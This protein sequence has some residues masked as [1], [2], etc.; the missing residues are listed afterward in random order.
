MAISPLPTPPSREDPANFATRAD[1]F[2]GALPTFQSE[3]NALQTDVN[4]RQTTASTAATTA[5]T[6]AGIATAQAVI[7]TT[8]AGVAQAQVA[9]A[10]TQ[11]GIATTQAGNASATYTNFNNQYL[12]SKASDPTLNNTGGA[13]VAG[14]LYYNTT[15][16]EMRVYSGSLWLAAYIPI[17]GYLALTGGT[18]TGAI[19]F[20]DGQTFSKII[21]P[22]NGQILNSIPTNDGDATGSTLGGFN[23]GYSSSAV[24]DL[25]YLDSSST[26][27][28][29]DA[30][31]LVLY[32]GLLGISLQVRASGNPLLVALPGSFVYA[33][34]F[35]TFTIGAP[36]YMSETP[37]AVTQ[38]A[39]I[40]S[41]SATRV[42]GW[43][44][45]ADKMYFF[46]SPDYIT[47]T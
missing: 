21:L 16:N 32:N 34:G 23:C 41:D 38:T 42:V 29:C 43:A 20:V 8:Q 6:Q 15:V 18:M 46:P 17:T 40:T 5:T 24:G 33:T 13:L 30:N 39:P 11:A 4:T 22:T 2:L 12:G 28:K 19:A 31:T 7:A 9:L 10:T 1:S 45:H 3:A 14:N 35:P 26:W 44:I 25:V 37:G 27:Q 36:I 47:H